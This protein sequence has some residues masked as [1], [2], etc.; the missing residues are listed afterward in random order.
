MP[1]YNSLRI[2][3]LSLVTTLTLTFTAQADIPVVNNVMVTDVTTVSFSVIWSSSEAST[4]D[5]DVFQDA[6]GTSPVPDTVVLPHPVNDPA[7]ASTISEAAENNGVMK[8]MV[9]GLQPDTTY[10]F[11]TITTS[12]S[13]TDTTYSPSSAPLTAVTTE[14]ETVR[15]YQNGDDV[16]P[17]SN[18]IIIEP[19]YL[20][21]GS[22]PADGS[23][24]IATVAGGNNPITAFVGDGVD[25]PYALI[26]LNNVFSREMF[27][28]LDLEQGENLTL[29]NFRGINGIQ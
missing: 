15:T 24:L 8:V 21:D 28:N 12:K 10:Y 17:F 25:S 5:L 18:D 26:D 3:I 19:C 13:T 20:D 29:V 16:L 2:F 14:S 7:M 9:T 4:A 22:T 27:E 11:Q 6:D 1:V 23:L